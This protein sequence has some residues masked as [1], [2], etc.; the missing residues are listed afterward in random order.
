MTVQLVIVLIGAVLAVVT[1][2][3]LKNVRR[4]LVYL[5]AGRSPFKLE[6]LMYRLCVTN[7]G[8]CV[9]LL[10]FLLC[11]FFDT[12]HMSVFVKV[13]ARFTSAIFP[14]LWVVSSKTFKKWN[15]I[16]RP[17]MT[18]KEVREIPVVKV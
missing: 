12:H 4:A 6:R 1:S 18:N 7:V 8:I 10:V 3:A 17:T 13:A 15:K 16:L 11:N 14:A 9:P 5:Y 2:V